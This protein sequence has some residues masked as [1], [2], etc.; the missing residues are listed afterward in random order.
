[1]RQ[2][3]L[4]DMILFSIILK[5]KKEFLIN[6]SSHIKKNILTLLTNKMRMEDGIWLLMGPKDTEMK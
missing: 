5:M 4:E 1:M 6:L 2:I 3:G